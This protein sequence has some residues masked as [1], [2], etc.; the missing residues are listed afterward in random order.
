ML[1]HGRYMGGVWEIQGRYRGDMREVHE[2]YKGDTGER[3]REIH[4]RCMGDID[5]V[6]CA[7]ARVKRSRAKREAAACRGDAG[8]I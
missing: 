7:A 6:T 3:C 1:V 2:R 8:E 5:I 4:G